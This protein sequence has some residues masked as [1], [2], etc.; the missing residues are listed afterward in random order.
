MN[1]K[2]LVVDDDAVGRAAVCQMLSR[3]GFEVIEAVDGTS[4]L[5]RF[6]EDQ[7][8]L[9]LLDVVMPEPNGFEVC[10]TLKADTETRLVPVVLLTGLDRTNDRVQ[11]IEAGADEFLSKPVESVELIARARSLLNLKRFTSA[12]H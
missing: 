12:T 7:P 3:N 6:K 9:V 1:G 2:I 4:A 5:E 10:R 11:G 8:D